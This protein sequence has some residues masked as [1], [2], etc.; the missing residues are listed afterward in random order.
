MDESSTPASL[1]LSGTL[2]EQEGGVV[3][4]TYSVGLSVPVITNSMS[5]PGKDG[6]PPQV[7]NSNIQYS[8][9]QATGTLRMK[10]GKS[11]ELLKIAGVTYML[12]MTPEPEK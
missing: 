9:H 11:Y 1:T 6:S 4:L 5:V 10:P 7:I 3:V 2:A 12:V 8:Q